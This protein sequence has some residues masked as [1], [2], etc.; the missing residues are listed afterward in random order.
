[1]DNA[2]IR[3]FNEGIGFHVASV[4]EETLLLPE[5]WWSYEDLRGVKSSFTLNDSWAWYVFIFSQFFFFSILDTILILFF[6]FFFFFFFKGY[7]KYFQVRGDDQLPL[8][9]TG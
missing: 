8:S 1:M 5:T 2:S 4:L 6:F 9:T 3:D 7:S